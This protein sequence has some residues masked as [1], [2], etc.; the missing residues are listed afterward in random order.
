MSLEEAVRELV[1]IPS[2]PTT[3]RILLVAEDIHDSLY[4]PFDFDLMEF[5]GKNAAARRA[6]GRFLLF[7]NPD[8]CLSDA[9]AARLARRELRSDVVYTTFR[10]A[11]VGH[12]PVGRAASAAPRPRRRPARRSA[13]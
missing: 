1:L 4:N 12:V 7:T 5:I 8:D 2:N 9:M 3:I 6:R 13:A 11:L 10:G